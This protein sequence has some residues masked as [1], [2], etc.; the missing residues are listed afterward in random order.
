MISGN[1]DLDS[2]VEALNTG[3]FI[4]KNGNIEVFLPADPQMINVN[5]KFE[6]N[7]E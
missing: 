7:D 6:G 5:V 4:V 2:L 1:E 3:N